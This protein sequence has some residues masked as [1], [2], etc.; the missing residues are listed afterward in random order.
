MTE[1]Q[2]HQKDREAEQPFSTIQVVFKDSVVDS[3]PSS[4][5]RWWRML[6]LPLL[7]LLL[8]A[9]I[10]VAEAMGARLF[11]RTKGLADWAEPIAPFC[12]PVV[13][14]VAAWVAHRS[15]KQRRDADNR[16]E[17]WRQVTMTLDVIRDKDERVQT[18]GIT[19]LR[20]LGGVEGESTIEGVPPRDIR[21]LRELVNIFD[22][23]ADPTERRQPPSQP[24][25]PD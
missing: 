8:I 24:R 6:R 12:I 3:A 18:G 25:N 13:A 4:M 7:F 5:L 22:V 15:Y 19:L 21:I 17:W 9:G 2:G 23:D 11:E 10:W 14:T 20:R 1:P 16:A